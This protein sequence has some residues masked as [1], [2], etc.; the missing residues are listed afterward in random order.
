[1]ASDDRQRQ[2]G[3]LDD[4]GGIEP[5]TRQRVVRHPHV[6]EESA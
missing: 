1:M 6:D 4:D 3:E 2:Q 5:D